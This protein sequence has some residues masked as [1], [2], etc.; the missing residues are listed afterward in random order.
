MLKVNFFRAPTM[1]Q[2]V[3]DDFNHLYLGARKPSHAARVNLN[4]SC[5]DGR[6]DFKHIGNESMR[7]FERMSEEEFWKAADAGIED[8]LTVQ[9]ADH[10]V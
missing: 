6:H 10:N 7:G 2:F 9:T 3:E 4:L 8:M 1:G 5:E